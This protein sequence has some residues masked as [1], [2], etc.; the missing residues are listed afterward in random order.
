M[1]GVVIGIMLVVFILALSAGIKGVVAQTLQMFG[2]D[3]IVV[4]PGEATNPIESV[5]ALVGG[6]R[7]RDKDILDLENIEGIRFVAPMDITTLNVEYAGEKKN[8]MLH[9]A[10]WKEYKIIYEESQGLKLAQGRWPENDQVNEVVLGYKVASDLFKE[11]VRVGDELVLKSKKMKVVGIL[12]PIGEQMAD[13]VIYLSLDIFRQLTG[14]RS[15][16]VSAA[17]K[18]EPGANLDLITKQIEFQL[19]Q[20]KTVEEFSVL[21]PEKIGNIIGS[22]LSVIETVLVIIALISLL[23]GGVGIM[24]TMYTSVLERT[25]QIGIMKAIG[26]SQAVITAL[27]LLES[28][29]IGFVGGILGTVLGIVFAYTIGMIAGNF[30]VQGLFSFASLDYLGFLSLLVFTFIVGVLAGVLPAR[31]AARME[32]AEALRYE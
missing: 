12:T 4:R 11:K 19:K 2:A 18:V 6:Q 14:V 26:A 13:N 27:F 24:N 28:G 16:I 7:F 1:L 9:G 15:G 21:T 8:T 20:Q 5:A 10:P 22:V 32:P 29:F 17:I 3:L 31:Q 30:G 25:K 23:V